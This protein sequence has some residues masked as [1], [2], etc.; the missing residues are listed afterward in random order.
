MT[1]SGHGGAVADE[2]DSKSLRAQALA[3]AKWL[4]LDTK[5]AL[6]IEDALP[7]ILEALQR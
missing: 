5:I 7:S 3:S 1:R 2:S 4:Q 6:T